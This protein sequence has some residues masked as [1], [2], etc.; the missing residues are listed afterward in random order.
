MKLY[1]DFN[2]QAARLIDFQ[3]I[4]CHDQ[5]YCKSDEEIMEFMKN[6]FILML[7]NKVRFDPEKY[8]TEAFVE[9]SV[10]EWI[11]INTQVTITLPYSLITSEARLIDAQ[12]DLDEITEDSHEALF[13]LKQQPA[14]AYEKDNFTVMVISVQ[15]S[16]D[17]IEIERTAYTILDV[18]SDCGGILALL[19]S[20]F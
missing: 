8:S 2:S 7:S 15:M 16:M 1:G 3:L 17:R 11:T 5:D 13:L 19:I 12:I 20:I 10:L 14:R 4:K 18:L 6:K 9:E